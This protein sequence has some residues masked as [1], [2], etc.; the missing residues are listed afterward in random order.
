MLGHILSGGHSICCLCSQ[1]QFVYKFRFRFS[2]SKKSSSYEQGTA[3]HILTITT[4]PKY[5]QADSYCKKLQ[6]HLDSKEIKFV[7][8]NS[9]V[10]SS[11]SFKLGGLKAMG[12]YIVVNP[13]FFQTKT[14]PIIPQLQQVFLKH[15]QVNILQ[16]EPSTLLFQ[17]DISNQ[18]YW[19]SRCCCDKGNV[20]N[21]FSSSK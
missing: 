5:F 9:L 1:K 6:S 8:V 17:K 7:G 20:E 3:R 4:P 10:F 14:L 18:N 12:P 13:V 15:L 19:Q 2:I 21:S 16:K 11:D